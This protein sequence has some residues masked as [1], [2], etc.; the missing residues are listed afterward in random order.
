MLKT[1]HT[2]LI[3]LLLSVF[4]WGKAQVMDTVCTQSIVGF[5]TKPDA[6]ITDYH[7]MW[8]LD[9]DTS[10][11]VD[12]KTTLNGDTLKIHFGNSK[13]WF[14]VGG[15]IISDIGPTGLNKCEGDIVWDSVYVWG[16]GNIDLPDTLIRCENEPFVLAVDEGLRSYKWSSLN[17][18]GNVYRGI[19]TKSDTIWVSARD[20]HNCLLTDTTKLTVYP[21]PTFDILDYRSGKAIKD[22]MLCGTDQVTLDAN[23]FA[24]YLNWNTGEI[25][26]Q[27]VVNPIEL[28]TKD[29]VRYYKATAIMDYEYA[30]CQ[31]EDSVAVLACFTG[32]IEGIPTV[33]TPNGD[34]HNDDWNIPNLNRD[35]ACTIDIYDRWGRLV[36]HSRG[37]AKN[38]DGK[39][40]DGKAL[41]M[42]NYFYIIKL[43]GNTKTLIGNI[44]IIR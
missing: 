42:D 19:A 2:I 44:T 30:S 3:L 43:S 10:K 33:I 28:N 20:Q 31:Y 7:I 12:S 41:P 36:F 4:A 1:K 40:N 11:I 6:L 39:G 8:H 34:G 14:R 23:S 24:T 38:W 27:I 21:L 26:Q 16:Y 9:F 35:P 25:S 32:E 13:G 29:T 5:Y 37:Y 17:G 22:T 15:Q 18:N